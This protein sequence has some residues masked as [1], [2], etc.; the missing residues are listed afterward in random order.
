[1]TLVLPLSLYRI[2]RPELIS[3]LEPSER[4]NLASRI[5]ESFRG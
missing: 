3:I 4:P 1:L 5:E 2:E